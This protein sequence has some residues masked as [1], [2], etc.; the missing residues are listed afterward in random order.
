MYANSQAQIYW[1]MADS[2]RLWKEISEAQ[3]NHLSFRLP[4]TRREVRLDY[5]YISTPRVNETADCMLDWVL[6]P[7]EGLR[8]DP[9]PS[10]LVAQVI[11]VA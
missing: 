3:E 10:P 6:Y 4:S 2:Y 9:L 5:R 8:L 1:T 7:R 11:F